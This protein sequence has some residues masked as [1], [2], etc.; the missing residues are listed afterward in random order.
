MEIQ[1]PLAGLACLLALPLALP[2]AAEAQFAYS[3]T[4]GAVTVTGCTGPGGAVSIRGTINGRPV[5]SI[6]ESAFWG[7]SSL[8]SV[9]IGNGVTNIGEGAFS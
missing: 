9:T 5:T 1:K 7:C 6:G 3:A 2:A 8:T 4:N